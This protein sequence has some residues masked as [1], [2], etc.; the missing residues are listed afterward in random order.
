MDKRDIL[1]VF[2]IYETLIQFINKNAYH[3]WKEITEEQK[4]IIDDNLNY[5]DRG[6][7]RKQVIIFRPGL[8]EFLA[9]V[10]ENLIG[11]KD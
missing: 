8:R 4:S 6:D 3:Y 2:D 1:I 11:I 9:M 7:Q 5:I 10:M